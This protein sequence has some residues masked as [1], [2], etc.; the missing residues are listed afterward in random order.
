MDRPKVRRLSSDGCDSKSH[1]VEKHSKLTE[2]SP[3]CHQLSMNSI[4][5][6]SYVYHVISNI[7]PNW[8]ELQILGLFY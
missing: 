8:K 4:F 1:A 5:D 7:N 2:I 6:K 3:D